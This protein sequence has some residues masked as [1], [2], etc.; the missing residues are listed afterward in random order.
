MSARVKENTTKTDI[1][2]D[3]HVF[4]TQACLMNTITLHLRLN[5]MLEM[6]SGSRIFEV[7]II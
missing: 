4:G 6:V 5:V 2:N 7:C 1:P 3:A